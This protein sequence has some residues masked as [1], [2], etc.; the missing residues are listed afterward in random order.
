MSITK[1]MK[2][3]QNMENVYIDTTKYQATLGENGGLEFSLRRNAPGNYF[4]H[5]LAGDLR[6]LKFTLT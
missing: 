4:K 1:I 3:T 2:K 6:P 5:L